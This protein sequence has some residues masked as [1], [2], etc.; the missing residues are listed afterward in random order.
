ML[1]ALLALAA[2]GH[3][4]LAL[5]GCGAV[6]ACIGALDVSLLGGWRGTG[7][8]RLDPATVRVVGGRT[9]VC[10]PRLTNLTNSTGPL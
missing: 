4:S 2:I 7:L 3:G 5:L 1:T 6:C 9:G 8:H 10:S